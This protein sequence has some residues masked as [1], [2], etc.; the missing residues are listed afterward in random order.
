MWPPADTGH[1]GA[2]RRKGT[3]MSPTAI[4]A[5]GYHVEFDVDDARSLLLSAA[6]LEGRFHQAS[7]SGLMDETDQREPSY[8]LRLIGLFVRP[9]G[10]GHGEHIIVASELGTAEPDDVVVLRAEHLEPGDGDI[11]DW[12]M[13]VLGF[14]AEDEPAWI[15]AVDALGRQ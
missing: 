3:L 6:H 14:P 4:L 8:L 13:H 2:H 15:L 12:A 7:A 10:D 1:A 5:Y 9:W 11:L